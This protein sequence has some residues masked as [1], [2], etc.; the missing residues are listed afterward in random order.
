MQ[1]TLEQRKAAQDEL[2]RKIEEGK[3]KYRRDF[4][5]SEVWDD[6]AKE[7]GIRL[8]DWWQ[9]PEPKQMARYLRKLMITKKQYLEACGEGSQ[10]EDF[11]RLNPE[12]P[13]RAFV[14]NILEYHD[15]ME[16]AKQKLNVI[17]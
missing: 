5:D 17:S 12:F 4:A 1:F 7:Y 14:G 9:A 8:P 10:L 11:A 13:L 3:A 15:G 16:E 2:K 6:L